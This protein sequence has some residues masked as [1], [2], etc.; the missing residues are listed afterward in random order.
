MRTTARLVLAAL[1]ATA[2]AGMARMAGQS[3]AQISSPGA[4]PLPL[5]QAAPGQDA[6]ASLR[7]DV[8]VVRQRA[9]RVDLSL[10]GG[11]WGA[12]PPV[13]RLRLPL[14]DDAEY[15]AT[16]QRVEQSRHGAAWIGVI[17]GVPLSQ[18]VLAVVGGDMTGSITMPGRSYDVQP[19][20]GGVH[21]AREI[22]DRLRPGD[23]VI[24]VGADAAE[25][26]IATAPPGVRAG[27]GDVQTAG[28]NPGFVDVL[29]AYTT[30]VMTRRGGE[31]ATLS[32]IDAAVAEANQ[33]YQNSGIGLRLRLAGTVEVA[34]AGAGD[35]N[36]DLSALR[37]TTDG[38]LDEIHALRN[39]LGADL[40]S[41]VTET[42]PGYCGM[43]YVLTNPSSAS[44]AASG[45][46]VVRRTCMTGYSFAHELGHNMGSQHDWY[47]TASAGAYRYSHGHIDIDG[48]FRTIMSYSNMCA[49]Q[50]RTCTRI[51][52]FSNPDV[53]RDG[54]R[55]GVP[56]GT[57]TTCTPGNA[58]NP[59]CDADNARSLNNTAQGVANFR[60]SLYTGA[61][62]A[63]PPRNE[64]FAFRTVL[65]SKYRDGL[66]RSAGPT[67]A[68][69][70]GSVVWVSEYLLYRVHQCSHDRSIAEVRMQIQGL[71]LPS[72]CGLPPAGTIPFPPRN[73]TYAMRLELE[74]IYR[75]ELKRQ[76]SQ[77]AVDVEGDVVWTQEYLRYRLNGC[78]HDQAAARVMTQID[79]GGIP[80]V[81][82]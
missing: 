12:L 45:F 31:N 76:P 61:A 30:E 53:S 74:T 81:C 22:D 36:A 51:A 67:Y 34:Y 18:V 16:L 24:Q 41:L 10:V 66:G 1:A 37:S 4:G 60:A 68:D 69:V 39:S 72:T 80:P 35:L 64:T 50:S 71:G 5:F 44:A 26:R 40:V 77:S 19:A 2:V 78:T 47:T 52:Y 8:S 43:A 23:G 29:V 11:A 17:E 15:V 79:G 73:E 56:E 63:F 48:G 46:S 38:K 28:D 82:R 75:D 58:A 14:F 33:A 21:L 6:R 57:G 32:M 49:D 42:D 27:A 55:T 62:V 20:G 65:E 9:V 59:P 13:E 70:E 54:R 25:E 3:P 7:E